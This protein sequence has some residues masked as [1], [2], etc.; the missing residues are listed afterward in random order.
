MASV[1]EKGKVTALKPGIA[2]IFAY[3]TF[4]GKT[5]SNS[6]P[7]KVMPDLTPAEITVDGKKIKGFNKDVKAYSYLLKDNSKIPVVKAIAL[8]KDIEVDIDPGK[9]CARNCCSNFC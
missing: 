1:D 4:N 3:V 8:D 6:Y 7:L 5:V 9:R 2:S